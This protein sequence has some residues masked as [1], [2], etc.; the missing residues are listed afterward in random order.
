MRM[1][2]RENWRGGKGNSASKNCRVFYFYLHVIPEI[3][4]QRLI[5]ERKAMI[6]GVS[7][8]QDF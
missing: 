1:E 6:I 8:G 5:G 7:H 4:W 2:I 3:P